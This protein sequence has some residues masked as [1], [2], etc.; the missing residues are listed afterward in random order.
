MQPVAHSS[1]DMTQ[2]GLQNHNQAAGTLPPF[3]PR[4]RGAQAL[5]PHTLFFRHASVPLTQLTSVPFFARALETRR[6][7]LCHA[8]MRTAPTPSLP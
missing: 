8:C 7:A 3:P 2:F 4:A 6:A 1:F 5:D